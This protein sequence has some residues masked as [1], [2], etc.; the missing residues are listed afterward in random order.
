M[1]NYF[2]MFMIKIILCI[3]MI[4]LV[5]IKVSSVGSTSQIWEIHLFLH[6]LDIRHPE[7][8]LR[9]LQ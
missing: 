5:K 7:S 8:R 4:P 2:D 6:K 3:I 1:W 9:R